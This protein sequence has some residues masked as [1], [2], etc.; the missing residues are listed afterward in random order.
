MTRFLKQ[1]NKAAVFRA[2][3]LLVM[4]WSAR[5]HGQGTFHFTFDGWRPGS[6]I[7]I[8]QY[9]ESGMWFRPLGVVEPGNG[10]IRRGGSNSLFPENGSAYLQASVGDS[11]MFSFTDG[12]LFDLTSV[13]LAEYSTVVSDAVA[14]PFVGYRF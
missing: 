11:L 2:V 13:D 10:F 6:A 9:F 12:R 8:E 14:V 4:L 5:C 7:F 1:T 3:G